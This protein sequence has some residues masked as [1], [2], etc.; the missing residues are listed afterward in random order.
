MTKCE[1]IRALIIG[2]YGY[3]TNGVACIIQSIFFKQILKNESFLQRSL[4]T[5]ALVFIPVKV[6]D[7]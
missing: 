6:P 4:D 7:H 2:L 5:N 1:P 3:L